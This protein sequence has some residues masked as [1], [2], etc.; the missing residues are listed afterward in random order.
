MGRACTSHRSVPS[1]AHSTSCGL[2]GQPLDPQCEVERV[3]H[4]LARVA[5]VA[6]A[7][8]GGRDRR[9]GSGHQRLARAPRPPRPAP[10]TVSPPGST[11]KTTPARR[12]GTIRMSTTPIAAVPS[13]TPRVLPVRHRRRV[14]ERGEHRL[15]RGAEG[16]RR[17]RHRR[18]APT[19]TAR[20]TTSRSR[21]STVAEDRTARGCPAAT[22]RATDVMA[23]RSSTL[24]VAPG[25]HVVDLVCS[26]LRPFAN[27]GDQ[28][29]DRLLFDEAPVHVG[30]DG[31]GRR[32]RK[33]PAHEAVQRLALATENAGLHARRRAR[34]AAR[35]GGVRIRS[36]RRR[37][38]Y[39]FSPRRGHLV[40]L[41]AGEAIS[42]SRDGAVGES[43][44]AVAV[45]RRTGAH[46]SHEVGTDR[47]QRSPR[48][49]SCQQD[50]REHAEQPRR[51]PRG[52]SR[53]R[54]P[55]RPD[56]HR[57]DCDHD[58]E[59]HPGEQGGRHGTPKRWLSSG[60]RVRDPVSGRAGRVESSAGAKRVPMTHS[61]VLE[62]LVSSYPSSRP[63]S[64]STA[65]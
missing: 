8:Q 63:P 43:L 62:A 44:G 59:R 5:A 39:R 3:D 15:D 58:G 27:R 47:H 53:P 60:N 7:E 18:R 36:A 6:R 38:P 55:Q 19:G 32:D 41:L 4:L 12:A 64:R 13:S 25:E 31:A 54:G 24:E 10:V 26:D 2:A 57:R 40:G 9:L 20:R 28:Q 48:R 65:R 29:G 35:R 21:S 46:P 52:P 34:T 61:V 50:R 42:V 37:R 16:H 45:D 33:P 30:V 11:V 56:P 14:P 17:R 49:R 23:P 1:H 51:S 22:S